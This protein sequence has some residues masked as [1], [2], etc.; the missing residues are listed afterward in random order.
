MSGRPSLFTPERARAALALAGG[1]SL[2]W[3]AFAAGVSRRTLQAWLERGRRGDPAYAAWAEEFDRRAERTRLARNRAWWNR[4]RAEARARYQ[5]F[6]RERVQWW[7]DRLGPEEFWRRRLR[8]LAA[9]G[10]TQAYERTL[11]MRSG[12]DFHAEATP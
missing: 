4:Y 1:D 11:A 12:A 7:L 2:R 5:R 6:R 8:W 3:V 10:Q 9:H